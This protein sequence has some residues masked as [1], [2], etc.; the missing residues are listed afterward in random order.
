MLSYLARYYSFSLIP[1]IGFLSLWGLIFFLF[2]INPFPIRHVRPDTV[3]YFVLAIF[4]VTLGYLSSFVFKFNSIE[5][6]KKQVHIDYN[7]LFQINS[8][9]L[10]LSFLG[11]YLSVSEIGRLAGDSLIYLKN[12]FKVRVIVTSMGTTPLYQPSLLYKLGS[13][14]INLGVISAF[15]SGFLLTGRKFY[16][17]ALLPLLVGLFSSFVFFSRYMLISYVLFFLIA[18]YLSLFY[19]S[20]ENYIIAKKRFVKILSSAVVFALLASIG[21]ILA[22]NFFLKEVGDLLGKQFFYY[23]TGGI[24]SFDS[25]LVHGFKDHTYGLSMTRGIN[26]WLVK[27]DLLDINVPIGSSHE[28][29]LVANNVQLNTYTFIKT[30]YQDFGLLGVSI[31]SFICGYFTH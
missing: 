15:T 12:P 6:K 5:L 28:F 14:L 13:Y 25:Y 30:L 29:I 31:T 27:L 7:R 9:L 24:S 16:K 21:I 2:Y 11:M 20:D 17:S 4:S 1:I 3:W 22:R 18:Y 10:A 23:L 8:L 19:T 26:Q